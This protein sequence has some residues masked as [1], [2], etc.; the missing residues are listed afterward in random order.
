MRNPNNHRSSFFLGDDL[1]FFYSS[2][3]NGLCLDGCFLPFI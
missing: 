3:T 1:D 2:L